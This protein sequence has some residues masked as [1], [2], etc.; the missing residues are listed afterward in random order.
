MQDLMYLTGFNINIVECK[1]EG[2]E[3]NKLYKESFNINIVECKYLKRH[4]VAYEDS[5]LI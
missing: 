5:V 3:R 1:L 2:K 4:S